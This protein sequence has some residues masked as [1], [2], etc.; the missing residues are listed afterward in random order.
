LK[1]VF[2]HIPKT[3]G[4]SIHAALVDACGETAVCPARVNEHLLKM[5][6]PQL[7]QYQVF[8]GHLDWALLDCIEGPKYVF[9]VLREPKDRI[10]SFYFYLRDQAAKM[11]REQLN[12]S[13]H[14]G[15]RAALDLSPQDYFL[16]GEP[17]LRH[18][19]DDHYDNFYT[20]YFAG[21]RYQSRG[22]LVGLI[23]RGEMS[24]SEVLRMAQENMARLD[25][26]FVISQLSEV[27]SKIRRLSGSAAQ[28]AQE[29]RVNVNRSIT[30][31]DRER[32]LRSL[33]AN[34][35]TFRRIEEFCELD[36][37]LWACCSQNKRAGLGAGSERDTVSHRNSI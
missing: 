11:P 32:R 23:K 15:M 9:T 7:N 16:G 12:R 8:S 19:L 31:S 35:E 5:S 24:R 17:H 30:P 27:A 21:R 37:H 4:Q 14:Q 26:V 13:E 34:D 2:L 29:Y 33:G 10:L 3:A 25:D 28:S 36:R 20:Y 22:Q 18:F 1:I 6:I